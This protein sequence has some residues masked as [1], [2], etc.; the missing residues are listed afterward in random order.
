MVVSECVSEIEQARELSREFAA[1]A[2]TYDA[3]GTFPAENFAALHGVGLLG[4]TVGREFGGGEADLTTVCRVI[5]QIGHGNPSTALILAM[6]L[7]HHTTLRRGS[8]WPTDV[9]AQVCRDAVERGALIN[10]LRVE[11]ELGTPARGGLPKTTAERTRAGW[12]LNGHKIY[13]TGAPGLSYYL[14][15]GHTAGDDPEVGSFLVPRGTPGVRIVETWDQFGMRATGSHDVLLED[16]E[17]P[18]EYAVDLRLPAAWADRDPKAAGWNGLVI[19][20]LYQGVARS[21][22][23]W[24]VDYLHGKEGDALEAEPRVQSILGEIEALLFANERLIYTHANEIDQGRA[25]ERAGQQVNMIKYWVTNNAVRACEAALEAVGPLGQSRR[26]PLERH[27]RDARCSVVHT[28]QDDTILLAAGRAA[29][30]AH[31]ATG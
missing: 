1:R 31:P 17:I 21:A 12:R 19:P 20:S 29:L 23:D 18:A 14:V 11:P 22:R 2:A 25:N 28:P 9:R 30:A 7:N 24:L 16:L 10:S 5:E 8:R 27:Y 26:C 15:W 3:S 6:Q 4:L 13:S